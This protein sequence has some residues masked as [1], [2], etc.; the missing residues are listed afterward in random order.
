MSQI[1]YSLLVD[2]E[3]SDQHP[4]RCISSD[5]EGDDVI[6]LVVP[7]YRIQYCAHLI[8]RLFLLFLYS[9]IVIV[10]TLKFQ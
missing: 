8:T 10:F 9:T 2:E 5:I 6:E 7:S 4:S 1:G 3:Y